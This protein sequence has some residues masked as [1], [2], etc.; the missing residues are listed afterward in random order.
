[1]SNGLKEVVPD[2]DEDV[3]IRVWE[4][5]QRQHFRSLQELKISVEKGTLTLE[6]N[7][8][9]FYEKQIALTI[10]RRTPGVESFDDQ[11]KVT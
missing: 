3:A 6:G 7:V 9:S 10:C 8:G 5:L 1:M 11:I 2:R 4:F